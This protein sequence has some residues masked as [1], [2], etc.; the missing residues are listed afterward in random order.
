MILNAKDHAAAGTRITLDD[1]FRRAG[2]RHPDALAL[3]DA[4]NR[5]TFTDGAP[6]RLTY[7][8]ADR[9]ISRFAAR[10]RALGLATDAVVALQLPNTVESVLALLGVLR[11][12]MIAAPLPLLWHRQD[13]VAA[14][15]GIGAKAI[16][17]C[18][19]AG[20]VAQAEV[21]MQLAAD[22]FPIRHVCAF[23][24][25]LPD[26]VVPLDDLFDDGDNAP[27]TF[28]R[29]ENPAAHVAAVTFDVGHG[30]TVAV[31]RDH[32]QL[33]AGGI[34]AYREAGIAADATLLSTIPVGSFAGMAATLLPWLLCGGTLA[35]HHAFDAD[36][37]AA[38]CRNLNPDVVVLPGPALARI[39]EAG[40]LDSVPGVLALWRAPERLADAALWH[41]DAALV[42]IVS[43]GE[44]CVV[45]ARRDAHGYPAS[46]A[47]GTADGADAAAAM[48]TARS[49]AGTL[50][51]RGPMVP[52]QAFPPGAE[53][54]GEAHLAADAAGFVDTGQPCRAADDGT[55]VVTGP[56]AG[57]TAV[58]YYRF[59][60]RAF[61]RLA[62]SIGADVR[63]AA[64]PQELTG[65]RLAGEAPDRDA[66]F[67]ALRLEGFN[68]LLAGAFRPRADAA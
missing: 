37:F 68:P 14:L 28:A 38:Q 39:A 57:M 46:L 12:G 23:G 5:E 30:G 24:E 13:A 19:R 61:D 56:P 15:A 11:A 42:D 8:Q 18:A 32:R 65:A 55:L 54:G 48:Q 10:L 1:L 33:I 43:F 66:V 67:Q 52:V 45:A 47:L 62:E 2:V 9:A 22:L 53:R 3:I 21:A 51:L 31:A 50:L 44:I 25:N 26:G 41:H 4:P 58:G 7:A 59:R 35:L 60:A 16:V 20:S 63:L 6:R 27:V 36:A 64:L 49:D 34:G 40:Y 17:T 29:A